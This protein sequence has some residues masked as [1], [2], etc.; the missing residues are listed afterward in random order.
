MELI[1][2]IEQDDIP[3]IYTIEMSTQAIARTI[4]E[5]TGARILTMHS[6]QT[7]TQDEFD[8]GESY[9]SLMWKNVEA[10]REGLN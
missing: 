2:R 7:V 3:V 10:L 4:A 6:L 5:E 8:G 9:V 1:Q